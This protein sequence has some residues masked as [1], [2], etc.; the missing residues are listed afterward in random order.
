MDAVSRT[1]QIDEGLEPEEVCALVVKARGG[2]RDAFGQ[3]VLAHQRPLFLAVQRIV[4]NPQDARDVVQRA[5]LKAWERLPDLEEPDRFRSW[6]FSI[7]INLGRNL[8]RDCGRRRFDPIEEGTL[9]SPPV[10]HR[11]LD[12][13][14]QRQQL[15]AALDALPARQREVVTLRI[16]AELSFKE[17]GDAVG[18]TE[19]T[20]RVNFHHGMKRL[21]ELLHAED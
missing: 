19:A 12:Q 13:H 14:Q 3:L 5:L 16:D 8:R 10:A 17:I 1:R 21:R 7:A 11:E 20:A 2:D 15:R 6:L 9:V 4:D 18:C